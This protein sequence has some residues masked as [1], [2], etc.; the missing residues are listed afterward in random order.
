MPDQ[1]IC[2]KSSSDGIGTFPALRGLPR[3]LRAVP[4]TAH[5]ETLLSR[6]YASRQHYTIF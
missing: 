5:D 2:Q 4:S 6:C 1:L 3:F